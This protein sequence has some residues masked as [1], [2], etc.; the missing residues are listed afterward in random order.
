MEPLYE[1]WDDRK[2]LIEPGKRIDWPDRVPMPR[3]NTDE[4]NDAMVKDLGISFRELQEKG[5]IAEPMRYR[6]F[7]EKGFNSPTGKNVILSGDPPREPICGSVRTRGT[8]CKIL[9]CTG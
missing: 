3:Q 9:R 8:L 6:K 2:I 1:C 7:L 5:Y 4:L